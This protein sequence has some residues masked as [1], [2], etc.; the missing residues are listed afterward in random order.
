VSID[1]V[2]F[3]FPG[4]SCKI[5]HR[6]PPGDQAKFIRWSLVYFSRPGNSIILAPLHD[7]SEMIKKAVESGKNLAT[8]STA[9]EWFERRVK[10][11]RVKNMTVRAMFFQSEDGADDHTQSK[12][13]WQAGRGTEHTDG[14]VELMAKAS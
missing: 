10:Y 6:S 11:L 13:K 5:F 7:K 9:G 1:L 12:D 4:R 2:F 3:S 14:K 8:T